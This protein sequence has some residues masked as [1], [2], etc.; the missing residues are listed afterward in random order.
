MGLGGDAVYYAFVVTMAEHMPQ[1]TEGQR[2]LRERAI[3]RLAKAVRSESEARAQCRDTH[4]EAA[5]R[6][7]PWAYLP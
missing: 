7:R 4:V 2:A 5:T 1:A 6:V 3:D